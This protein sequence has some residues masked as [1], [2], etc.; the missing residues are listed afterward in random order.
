MGKEKFLSLVH[1]SYCCD[2]RIDLDDPTEECIETLHMHLIKRKR[3]EV[4]CEAR[5]VTIYI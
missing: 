1:H 4:G 2:K 5:H 3:K